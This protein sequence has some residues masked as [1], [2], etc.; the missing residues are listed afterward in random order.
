MR[1]AIV[2]HHGRKPSG[3][4]INLSLFVD[5]LPRDI[6]PAFFL[7]EEGEFVDALRARG[8][9]VTVLPMSQ[10]IDGS[11]RTHLRLDAVV[12]SLGLARRLARGFRRARADL[13]LTNSMKAHIIGSLAARF[14]GI[15]CVNFVHDVPEGLARSMLRFVSGSFSQSRL[16]CSETTAANL[17][18]PNTTVIYSPLETERYL[19]L[20]QKAAAR[21]RLGIPA[22]DRPLIALVGRIAPWKGQD[23]FIRIAALVRERLDA[24]FAIVGSPVFGA[25]PGYAAELE[26]LVARLGLQD[27][28]HFIPWQDDPRDA[29]AALDVGCNCSTRE[30]F[31]RTTVEAMAAARAVVCFD[32]C[33]VASIFG[34]A[35]GVSVVPA[36]R[37]DLFA[38]AIATLCEDRAHLRA[39]GERAALAVRRLDVRALSGTFAAVLQSAAGEHPARR[40]PAA[41]RGA[42]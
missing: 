19:G 4:E 34:S 21:A 5:H 13:V 14:A 25:T 35:D 2:N 37:E 39:A 42:A 40:S 1:L 18:L 38:N 27:R 36:G 10:R 20:P 30:P 22:D 33:G 32:D 17:A 6:E 8:R 11:S 31:G 23:R 3:A 26:G 24:R 9:D 15:P 41:Q 7:L 12:D 29:Y 28:V 16:A